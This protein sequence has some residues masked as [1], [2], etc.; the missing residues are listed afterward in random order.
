M[1]LLYTDESIVICLKPAGTAS[2]E[3]AGPNM[4]ALLRE[5]LGTAEIYPVHRLDTA[6]AGAMVFAR[7]KA[8]AAAL[9]RQIAENTFIKEYYAAVHGQP[10][11]PAGEYTD[12]LFKDAKKNK[13]YVVNAPRRGVRE[14]KLAY[15]SLGTAETPRGPLTLVR[16]RLFTGRTHQIRVQFAHRGMP[17]AG[18]GK[19]GA[20]DNAPALALYSCR[21]AFAHPV[22]GQAMDFRLPLPET[23][24]WNR[25]PIKN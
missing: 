19:Y 20:K 11:P 15:T 14:A 6:A 3:S 22:T 16:V 25:I 9:S 17:L 2:Q 5:A 21:L 4:P 23:A 7:T 24:P 13:S 18:D 1:E 12:L 8:A 10:A